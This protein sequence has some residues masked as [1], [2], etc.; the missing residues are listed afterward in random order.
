MKKGLRLWSLLTIAFISTLFLITSLFYGLMV[1]QTA[2]SVRKTESKLL[3]SI[4]KQLSIDPLVKQVLTTHTNEKALE[5][6]ATEIYHIYDLD[7]VVIMN[8]QAKRLTHPD[9]SLI[10]KPFQGNDEKE[11]LKGHSYVSFSKGSLGQSLRGFVPVYGDNKQQ[12]GVVALG[13]K[14]Q[15]LG[16]LINTF[17]QGYTIVLFTSI[18]IGFIAALGIAYYLKRQ[19]LNLEPKEI[20]QLLEERNAMLSHTNDAIIVVNSDKVIQLSN[21]AANEL[22]EK[23]SGPGHTLTGLPLEALIVELDAVSLDS[24]REQLYRQNGQEYLFSSAPIIIQQ[25]P[26]GWIIF[27]RNA[28]ESLFVM[29]QLANTTAYASALQAQSHEFMN[30]LHVIYGL[31]DLKAYDELS[32]YLHDILS[33]EKEFSHRLSFLVRNPQ[34]AGF[35]IGERQKFSE[36]KVTLL[37]DISPEIPETRDDDETL[38]IMNCY[39]YIHHLLLKITLPEELQILIQYASDNLT[40]TYTLGLDT[41]QQAILKTGCE[42]PFFKQLR[43]EAKATFTIDSNNQTV[44]LQLGT[45]YHEVS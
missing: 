9:A 15:T 45:P 24:K 32:I 5:T 27:L 6:Y 34:I 23:T 29:D 38:A 35:L 43:K 26:I 36:R 17:R 12:I 20:S 16:T 42:H 11:A 2:Q 19:L 10:G 40:T 8:M 1:Y 13:V 37:F 31:V 33:P 39:R 22:Y 14:V 28:T 21:I 30:K 7:F 25:K 3:L 44:V 41:Q 4:G 18:A